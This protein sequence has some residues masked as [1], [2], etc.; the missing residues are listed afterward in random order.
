MSETAKILRI[1]KSKAQS[2]IIVDNDGKAYHLYSSEENSTLHISLLNED[3]TSYSGTFV[4]LFSGRYMEA[5]AICKTSEGQ[6]YFIGSDCTGWAPNEARSAVA[7]HIFGPYTEL[8]NPCIGENAELTFGG[9]S[10]YILPVQGKKDAFIFMADKWNPKNPIDGRYIWLPIQFSEGK[11]QIE[12]L[13]TWEL[14]TF[15]E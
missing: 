3:Y 8:G 14:S 1:D 13:D 4:R 6:Y 10:T 12:W 5:P 11:M 9:Q 2:S 15:D 7:N